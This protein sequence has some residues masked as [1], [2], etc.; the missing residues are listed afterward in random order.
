MHVKLQIRRLEPTEAEAYRQLML[1]AYA[2]HPDAFTSS[3]EER[4]AL[5][6]ETWQARMALGDDAREICWGAF[7][8]DALIG[9]VGLS[10]ELRQKARHKAHLL[11]LYVSSDWRQRGL[12]R[13]LVET[14]LVAAGQREGVRLVQLTVTEGNLAALQLYTRLGFE[15]FGCE[16]MAVRV[17]EGFVS[18]LHLWLDLQRQAGDKPIA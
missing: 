16:P 3:V 4:A 1:E 17:G 8:G 18:K 10:F 15:L 6:L 9:A 11:G 7:A 14:A 13:A 5:P 12:A 2:A